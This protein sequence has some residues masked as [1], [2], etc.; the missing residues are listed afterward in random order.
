MTEQAEHTALQARRSA[1]RATLFWSEKGEVC[2]ALHSPFPGS[3]SWIWERWL[4]M[5]EEERREWTR[6][7]GHPPKCEV[8]Q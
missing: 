6:L 3:D 5:T 8:C 1:D 2:C 7:L 4:P